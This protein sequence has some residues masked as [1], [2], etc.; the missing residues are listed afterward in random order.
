MGNIVDYELASAETACELSELVKERILEGWRLFG[1]P[2]PG[3]GAIYQALV[4]KGRP[5]KRLRKTTAD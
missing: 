5:E 2:F 1:K 4:L 3:E